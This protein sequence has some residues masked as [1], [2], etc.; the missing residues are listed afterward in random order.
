MPLSSQ[1]GP[2]VLRTTDLTK[3]YGSLRAVDH[4]TME[5][6]RGEV[7]GFLGPNG[8][9]K[10]TTILMM[11]G[12]L[13]PTSGTVWLEQENQQHFSRHSVGL[14]PQ[15]NIFWAKLTCY[16]QLVFLAEIYN[17]NHREA[18]RH[19]SFLL[20]RMGLAEKKNTLASTLSGGLKRRL[21][22]CMALIHNPGLVIFDE[23]EAGLDP[24]SR[25]MVREFIR[26]LAHEKTVILTTHNM[27]E[28]D[29]VAD[30]VAIIDRGKLL[31]TDTP[32]NLKKSIGEGD[33]LEIELLS[34]DNSISALA[35]KVVTPLVESVRLSGS[36]LVLLA[37]DMVDRI[38]G[39]VAHLRD[40]GITTGE[41]RLRENSLEDV[42]ITLTGRKLRE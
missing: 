16:E 11:C 6:F 33:T 23:P 21:N 41:F 40:A 36:S 2:T 12:L 15:E 17:M 19:A 38:P 24:Q 9:G 28:A 13:K 42:F 31:T 37:R 34:Q 25:V 35:V 14:C 32:A 7:F 39:I 10:T 4:L 5:I 18:R 26:E 20:E 8:A 3:D 30:R 29:R 27:D 22:I 1:A